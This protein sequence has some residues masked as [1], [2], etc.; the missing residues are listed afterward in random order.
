[1][2][3]LFVTGAG[4]FSFGVTDYYFPTAGVGFFEFDGD[5]RCAHWIEPFLGYSGPASFPISLY[6]GVFIHNDPD[7]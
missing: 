3:Y 4:S 2:G 7:N 5:G 1:M 6:G